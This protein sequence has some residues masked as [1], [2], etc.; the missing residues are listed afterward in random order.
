MKIV[1]ECYGYAAIGC[2]KLATVLSILFKPLGEKSPHHTTIRNWVWRYGCAEL[3][4]PKEK[5]EDWV[6]IGDVTV[7]LGKMKVLA[8]LGVRADK[9]KNQVDPV[10]D[11]SNQSKTPDKLHDTGLNPNKI[12]SSRVVRKNLTLTYEDVEILALA[13]CVSSNGKFVKKTF[14]EVA[15]KIDSVIRVIVIDRGPDMKKGAALYK[16]DQ[17]NT[18]I[19]HDISHKLSNVMEK[20]LKD[21]PAWIEYTKELTQTRHRVQQ[22]EFAALMP[23]VLRRD[24]RF[25][26]ISDIVFWP[27]RLQKIRENGN[28][29]EI[30]EERYN[31]YLGWINKYK[32]DRAEW[33][34][35][36]K[37]AEMIKEITRQNWLSKGIY[38]YMRSSFEQF[39]ISEGIAKEF[40]EA[41]MSSVFEEVE[42]LGDDEKVLASTEILESI[43]GRYKLINA[44][45]GQ[46][47]TGNVLGMCIFAGQELNEAKVIK[48]MEECSTKTMKQWVFEHVGESLGALRKRFFKKERTEFDENSEVRS[49]A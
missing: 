8:V 47:V 42:K 49:G 6:I 16:D 28:L 27:D 24:A 35:M 44:G 15:K 20:A 26:D 29:K 38:E 17:P 45:S 4:S 21:N 41:A 25:M 18:V 40:I 36:V 11:P 5:G 9:I 31:E 39:E 30:S 32:D 2:R 43:F 12:Q 23:P 33:E 19:I 1:L 46:G 14:D 7:S 3:N 34:I 37:A 10:F 48:H 13:P 22:T